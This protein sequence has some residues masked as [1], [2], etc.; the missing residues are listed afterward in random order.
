MRKGVVILGATGSIG[1]SARAALAAL[2][3]RFHV[4]GLVARNNLAELAAQAAEFRPEWTVTTD[5]ARAGELAELLPPDLKAAGG[6]EKVHE[7]V[8][9]PQTDIVLC[10]QRY[11]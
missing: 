4:V 7:L 11:G 10:I 5:P 6:M 9:A 8:T 3:K 1:R 2:P